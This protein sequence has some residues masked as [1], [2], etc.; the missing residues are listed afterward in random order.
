MNINGS[1]S[2]ILGTVQIH[3]LYE[4][5]VVEHIVTDRMA[6]QKTFNKI[7]NFASLLGNLSQNRPYRVDINVHNASHIHRHVQGCRPRGSQD[8]NPDGASITHPECGR[9]SIQVTIFH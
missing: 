4:H 5:I 2:F 7:Q 3:R 9:T 8:L 1:F 6:D